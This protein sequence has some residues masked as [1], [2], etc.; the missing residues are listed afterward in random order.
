MRK[1]CN[2]KYI[3]KLKHEIKNEFYKLS[4][5]YKA[6]VLLENCIW[7]PN[8]PRLGS[9]QLS[10]LLSCSLRG[11]WDLHRHRWGTHSVLTLITQ[12]LVL[13]LKFSLLKSTLHTALLSI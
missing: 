11:L 5:K 10:L 9:D 6:T 8:G 13:S 3:E 1:K 7:G 2:V 12:A 4:N